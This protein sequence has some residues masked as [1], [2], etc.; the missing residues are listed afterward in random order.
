MVFLRKW[1][2]IN[3]PANSRW[4]DS[5][6]RGRF[7]LCRP[8]INDPPTAVGGI[9]L[10]TKDDRTQP[11]ITRRTIVYSASGRRRPELI[12]NSQNNVT[13]PCYYRQSHFSHFGARSR[14]YFNSNR[15][16]SK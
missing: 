10:F 12:R 4:R 13:S 9:L 15:G 5:K 6:L 3:N 16:R 8:H 14:T 7:G 2:H 1:P 11:F